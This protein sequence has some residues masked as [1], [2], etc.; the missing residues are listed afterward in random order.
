MI[1]LQNDGELDIRAIKTMGLH[2]KDCDNPIG[3]FGTGLKYA[4]AV[5]L[6]ENIEVSIFIGSNRYIF[7]TETIE[8]RGNTKHLCKMI[9][10]SDSIDLGFTTDMGRNWELWQAY[11]EIHSNCLDEQGVISTESLSPGPGKTTI[12]LGLDM[13]PAEVFLNKA[14][15]NLLFKNSEVEIYEGGS[16]IMFYQGIRAKDLDSPSIYTYNIL[17]KCDLTEDRSLSYD[18]QISRA[19]ADAVVRMDN[20]DVIETVVTANTGTFE[21][22]LNLENNTYFE[23]SDT[24][25]EVVKAVSS[26]T[27][28]TRDY[29]EKCKPVEP[30]ELTF[31]EKIEHFNSNIKDIIWDLERDNDLC[32]NH[33]LIIN[34]KGVAVITIT[35]TEE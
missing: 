8:F 33:D 1:Y 18:H 26:V 29:L 5:L 20:K 14:S 12:M 15:R 28:R 27:P 34:R 21:Y 7:D 16:E 31:A 6:R 23:P 4:L 3:Y 17:K 22:N 13:N 35:I 19:I 25:Q 9:G 32:I 2:G 10:P 24:M 11:R 30:V